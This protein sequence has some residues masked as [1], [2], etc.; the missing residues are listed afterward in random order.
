VGVTA[1][2]ATR[3]EKRKFG[4]GHSSTEYRVSDAVRAAR[5]SAAVGVAASAKTAPSARR[6]REFNQGG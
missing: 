1:G 2:P 3:L 6:Q 5:R 4:G